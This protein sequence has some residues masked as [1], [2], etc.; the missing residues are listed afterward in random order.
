[1]LSVSTLILVGLTLAL[2]QVAGTVS[3]LC[4]GDSALL[5]TGVTGRSWMTFVCKSPAG[6][7]EYTLAQFSMQMAFESL[8]G[9]IVLVAAGMLAFRPVRGA[10]KRPQKA[11]KRAAVAAAPAP[12][13]APGAG[14]FRVNPNNST[15]EDLDLVVTAEVLGR[16]RAGEPNVAVRRVCSAL[17][18]N[19]DTAWKIVESIAKANGYSMAGRDREPEV[20]ERKASRG[21]RALA[22]SPRRVSQRVERAR[23]LSVLQARAESP[24][25][26]LLGAFSQRSVLSGAA[27]DAWSGP[28]FEPPKWNAP[29]ISNA[30][31]APTVASNAYPSAPAPVASTAPEP[32]LHHEAPSLSW[33]SGSALSGVAVGAGTAAPGFGGALGA[34]FGSATA[35]IPGISTPSASTAELPADRDAAM[36]T[37]REWLVSGRLTFAEYEQKRDEVQARSS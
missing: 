29:T 31:T 15:A 36:R 9:G 30:A 13:P 20:E 4:W 23:L 3:G 21:D 1:M 12:A 26:S 10:A 11:K 2:P 27:T 25:A 33:S 19:R 28:V 18:C 24:A 22:S 8:F 17:D 14:R 5:R 34:A 7:T 35:Q 32:G 37:L 16:L 6:I